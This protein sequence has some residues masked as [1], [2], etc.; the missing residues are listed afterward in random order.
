MSLF[1]RVRGVVLFLILAPAIMPA[2]DKPAADKPNT[3]KSNPDVIVF[4]NGDQLTGTLVRGVGDSII[5][6]SDIVGEV[7]IPLSKIKELR[8]NGSFAVLKK[9]TPAT[10][11]NTQ[12]GMVTVDDH[13]VTLM[14]PMGQ[15]E[16]VPVSNVAYIIDQS[17][18]DR[19]LE[20]KAGPL[21]GWAGTVTGGASFVQ[22]TQHGGTFTAGV[23]LVR[24]IPSVPYLQT[25]NRT[26]F[27]LS[28]AYGKLTTPV[29]PQTTPPTPDSVVKTSIFHTDVERDQY[30]SKKFYYLGTLAFDHNF[31]SGL[32][33]QQ[34]YGAGVGWT[35]VLDAKQQLDVKGDIHYE[36]QQFE[37]STS[38]LNLIGA[39][40]G[41][42]Y[43]RTLPRS[44]I[45]TQ[46]LQFL[47]AFNEPKA[48]SANFSTGLAMPVFKKLG[49]SIAASDSF[50]NNPSPGFKKNTFQF[51]TGVTYTLP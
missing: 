30:V 15:V 1:K 33:L 32:D 7:T 6:K 13:T 18:Y 41:E 21:Y 44:M 9:D 26:I 45:F 29:I 19:E 36:K 22:S 31:S 48:Y 16:T 14:H 12:T 28:E 34:I 4:K 17:V 43:K 35:P 11:T 40:I 25:R 39:S 50:L 20:K 38:N 47:P 49:M 2:E 42:A 37:D 46:T 10:R 24:T 27:D 51:I 5:F 8:S 23:K 3:E